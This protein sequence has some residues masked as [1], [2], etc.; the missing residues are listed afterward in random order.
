MGCTNSAE[1]SSAVDAGVSDAKESSKGVKHSAS[2]AE[3]ESAAVQERKGK[4][5]GQKESK[6]ASSAGSGLGGGVNEAFLFIKPHAA[7]KATRAL[8][9]EKLAEAGI[10]VTDEGELLGKEIDEKGA[11]DD[12]YAHIAKVAMKMHP[13]EILVTE[14]KK[15]KF[16]SAFGVT[17]E[18]A[19]DDGLLM[20]LRAFLKEFPER[21]VADVNKEWMEFANRTK[22]APGTYV[23]YFQTEGRYVMNAFYGSMRA[24][25]TDESSKIIYY[26]VEFKED[27][28]SWAAFRKRIIGATDPEVAEPGSLRAEILN[29][30][31]ALGLMKIPDLGLNGIHASAG[32]FEGLKERIIWLGTKVEDDKFAQTL[33]EKGVRRELLDA[34]LENGVITLNGQTDHAFDLLEDLDVTDAIRI[35]LE[36]SSS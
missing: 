33:L 30:W 7:T 1:A 16:E 23:G 28:L 3:E 8:V 20:N 12:H 31:E 22:L 13:S 27:E 14:D 21:N 18:E 15:E 24:V 32:P 29:R 4:L 5:K 11:I 25:Y 10:V 2:P 36:H 9:D 26:C 17:W 34:W 35:A 19:L 6:D